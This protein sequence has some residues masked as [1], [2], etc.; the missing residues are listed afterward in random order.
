[1]LDSSRTPMITFRS[2]SLIYQRASTALAIAA[3]RHLFV[4]R[5]FEHDRP[6]LCPRHF[7]KLVP[8][9]INWRD[10]ERSSII[11]VIIRDAIGC[12][13]LKVRNHAFAYDWPLDG[14]ARTG[15]APRTRASAR[16][17]RLPD[18]R[19]MSLCGADNARVDTL[20][21]QPY[22]RA[23]REPWQTP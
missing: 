19:T 1:M 23:L 3:A 7:R 18:N 22:F 2:D 14:D 20:L 4:P 12:G 6:A 15:L 13:T 8:L 5:H 11:E 16:R 9:F 17:K 21:A 10:L